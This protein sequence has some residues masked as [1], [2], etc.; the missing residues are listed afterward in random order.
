MITV[1]LFKFAELPNSALFNMAMD[2]K[3]RSALEGSAFE[4]TVGFYT[5]PDVEYGADGI[6]GTEEFENFLAI[7]NFLIE[8]ECEVNEKVYFK[9]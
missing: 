3:G 4:Y 1:K 9:W 8:N 6:E 7:N 2:V 5:H